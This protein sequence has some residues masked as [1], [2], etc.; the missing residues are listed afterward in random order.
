V[1][2]CTRLWACCAC[3]R[4]PRVEVS[5]AGCALHMRDM[6]ASG[7]ARLPPTLTPALP[8]ACCA[9]AGGLQLTAYAPR[10]RHHRHCRG[11]LQQPV[12]PA[13]FFF[14]SAT[15][16]L[17]CDLWSRWMC[18]ASL[19]R[20][21]LVAGGAGARAGGEG[22]LGGGRG[23]ERRPA[24]FPAAPPQLVRR[25]EASGSPKVREAARL[26]ATRPATTKQL[27]GRP[28]RQPAAG[29]LLCCLDQHARWRWRRRRRQLQQQW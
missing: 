5:C 18:C 25:S 11:C 28:P 6:P 3:G 26:G 12:A 9:A 14:S 29:A 7:P 4:R 10:L 1:L 19:Q 16:S 20:R 23:V 27:N 22:R 17:R 13:H 2:G 21:Y 15:C 24:G 8:N